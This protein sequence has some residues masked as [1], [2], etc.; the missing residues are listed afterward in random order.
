M[1]TK[2]QWGQFTWELENIKQDLEAF[3]EMSRVEK[4]NFA[5]TLVSRMDVARARLM[6]FRKTLR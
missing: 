1:Q 4:L 6:L 5:P 2:E 3:L